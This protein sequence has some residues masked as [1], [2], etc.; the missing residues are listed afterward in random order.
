MIEADETGSWLGAWT[1]LS[2]LQ[3]H[4]KI[5]LALVAGAGFGLVAKRL[6]LASFVATYVQPVGTAFVRLIGMVVVPLVFASLLIGIASLK[7]V[8]SLGR[9][10]VKTIA[11]YLC[12]TAIAV[13]IGLLLANLTR[14]GLG[15]AA[16]AED[17]LTAGAEQQDGAAEA[18]QEKP[19]I[20]D[21]L[22]NIIPT[23]PI[24]AFA[25]GQML[26]IIFFALLAG[27]CLTLIGS[28]RS[29]PAIR[30]FEAVNDT[31]VMMVHLIMKVAPFGVF[32]LISA[33]VA[34]FGLDILR[35]LAGYC[36]V[37]VAGLLMHILLVYSLALRL[38]SKVGM[39]RFLRGIRPAQLIA[40]SSSSSSA[41]LP[42]T[43]ECTTENLGVARSICSFTL[44]LGATINM[45]GTSLYQGVS[46]VFLAQ[47]YGMDLSVAQQLAVVLTATLAS[48]GTAGTPGAGIVTLAVVLGS[49]G[50]PL[51]GIGIIMG[52]ERVLDMCRSV[53]NVTGDAACAVVVAS[54][55]NRVVDGRGE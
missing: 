11:F 44:P 7:D 28:E 1:A 10:G 4:T 37:V 22:L 45:D 54:T 15:L 9:I 18:V 41:T 29:G 42:V 40:F 33:V 24:R 8:G 12:T 49:I 34:D 53:V 20:R 3:L 16:E 46:A 21:V 2:K 55:E 27:V 13:S 38:F 26:Q 35:M 51:Q 17:K 5:L 36:V 52:V 14:P 6:G 23:N 31:M 32:A 47:L 30:F 39:R 48:V 50:V 43:I 19:S 25:E